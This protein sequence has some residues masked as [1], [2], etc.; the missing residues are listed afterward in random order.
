MALWAGNII[1]DPN[2]LQFWAK[3]ILIFI[4]IAIVAKIITLILFSIINSV[5][6]NEGDVEITDERD[7]LVELKATRN[8]HIIFSLGFIVSLLFLAF[9]MQPF[10]MVLTLI[11]CAVIADVFGEISQIYFYTRGV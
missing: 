9:G 11:T 7:K 5:I 1:K 10:V 4:P 2:D 8:S 6:T 3:S